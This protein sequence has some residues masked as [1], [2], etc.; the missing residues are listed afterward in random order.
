V[1][2]RPRY[3]SWTIRSWLRR[4][5]PLVY[6][7][8]LGA[9]LLVQ[10]L[11][12]PPPD[13]EPGETPASVLTLP[14]MSED[15]RE[16]G[17]LDL[18]YRAWDPAR[19][20]PSARPPVLIIHGSPGDSS[21][22]EGLARELAL[23]GWP[24]IAP[25]LPGFGLS[26]GEV[27][28]Y[29]SLAQ[30]RSMAALL[31]GLAIDRAHIVGWSNGGAVGLWMADLAPDRVASLTLLAGTGPQHT[32][33]SGSYF[34]EHVKYAFGVA[35]LIGGAEL[36]PH[37]GLLGSRQAR[38]AFL[39]NFWDSDQRPLEA[40]MRQLEAPTLILHGRDDFLVGA[41]AAQE[42]QRL[43][44]CSRLV[45]TDHDHFMP[46]LAPGAT[47]DHLA[48]FLTR[49][50]RPGVPPLVQIADLAPRPRRDGAVGGVERAAAGLRGIPWWV[51][52]LG[53]G[54]LALL[55]RWLALGAAGYLVSV[56]ALDFGV[57]S[58]A[59]L[60]AAATRGAM[61]R[62]RGGREQ[63]WW[64]WLDPGALARAAGRLAW[65][66]VRV[67]LALAAVAA[68]GYLLL[69]PV[70]DGLGFGGLALWVVVAPMVVA[71]GRS[72]GA[73][74]ARQRLKARISRLWRHEFW[75]WYV[76]YAP[77]LPWLAWLGFR[78]RGI[79][80]FTCVNPALGLGGGVIGESKSHIL[81]SLG[82][83]PA[84]LAH[85]MLPA[86][87]DGAARLRELERALQDRPELGGWPII[88][89]PDRG[90][91]G[92]AVRLCRG[93]EDALDYLGRIDQ[94]VIAQR[95]HP[96]PHECSIFW[97]RDDRAPHGG[98]IFS[99]TR[100]EFQTVTGD[101]RRTLQALVLADPRLRMQADVFLDRFADQRTRVLAPG[102][103]LRM[104]ESGNH[105]QGALFRDGADLASGPLAAR[106][107]A[108]VRRIEDACGGPGFDFGRMDVRYTS[109][110]ALRRGRGLAVIEL[111]GASSESTN[112][113]DPDGSLAWAWG[114]LL[115]QWAT[116][117]RMGA[118]RRAEG[119][120]PMGAG[121][122]VRLLISERLQRRAPVVSS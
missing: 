54:A 104:S 65:L 9:S 78:Y 47:A 88:L 10:A 17:D 62:W 77:L 14:A 92:Y 37:F 42:H 71:A 91:R 82:D 119:A 36:V 27:P 73:W 116:V 81:H 83:D 8:A 22:F 7:L 98:R 48:P 44:P 3:T 63:P 16:P 12:D 90:E 19:D 39:R 1:A 4:R 113:Y 75:P 30:A 5:W 45:I 96:G 84:V 21:N 57:A 38:W 43:I 95:Y 2:D 72:V 70:V 50:D 112:M 86:D 28:S 31:D 108:I 53:L 32:E 99:M 120:R 115:R 109:D 79:M 66:L 60:L 58:V 103:T 13:E 24:V 49:H 52:A 80:T 89:K 94:D 93:P 61:R 74:S 6:L 114:V 15:G 121:E 101:G 111:N 23:R 11:N 33:G 117:Y 59:L 97:Q 18:A 26:R 118:A 29:S 102:E 41:W 122:L 20:G 87:G 55:S 35:V 85:A 69:D 56:L 25:D 105:A 64:Q 68:L 51:E 107:G 40:V 110:E 67:L 46:L 34:F 106:V 76:F 100:K